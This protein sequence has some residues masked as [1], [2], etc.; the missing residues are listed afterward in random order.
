MKKIT[1][2]SKGYSIKYYTMVL[3]TDVYEF[4]ADNNKH[5]IKDLIISQ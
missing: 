1:N 5:D 2:K 4:N 3:F